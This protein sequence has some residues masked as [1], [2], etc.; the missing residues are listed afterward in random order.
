MPS[1]RGVTM[2]GVPTSAGAHAPGQEKAPAA[3]RAAGLV[4]LLKGAASDVR[5]LGDLPVIRWTPD[6]AN[7]RAQ[8]AGLVAEVSERVAVIVAAEIA[9]ATAPPDLLLILGGDC[10][11]EVAADHASWPVPGGQ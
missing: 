10:T 1:T 2:I 4:E 5:D 11:I 9:R 7:P 3:F 8:H 6:R